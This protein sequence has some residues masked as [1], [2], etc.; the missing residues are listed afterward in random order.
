MTKSV[1]QIPASEQGSP[2]VLGFLTFVWRSDIFHLVFFLM[3]AHAPV[4]SLSDRSN[5][6]R[7]TT[8]TPVYSSRVDINTQNARR[9]LAALRSVRTTAW[10]PFRC[11]VW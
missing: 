5:N 2:R 8:Y 7:P 3:A 9:S 1:V 10:W 6:K 4:F 11:D